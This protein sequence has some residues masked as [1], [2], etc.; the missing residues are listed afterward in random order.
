MRPLSIQLISPSRGRATT[1]SLVCISSRPFLGLL[2]KIYS[3]FLSLFGFSPRCSACSS[4]PCLLH[5][6]LQG[7]SAVP[8]AAPQGQHPALG[9]VAEPQWGDLQ[10]RVQSVLQHSGCSGVG[11]WPSPREGP[12][13][14]P[15]SW[16][17]I[18][19]EPYSRHMHPPTEKMEQSYPSVSSFNTQKK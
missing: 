16:C 13:P 14:H 1:N 3:I 19:R 17:L 6:H 18:F 11:L 15:S 10:H 9:W 8:S 7:A 12:N 5:S 4:A 2:N